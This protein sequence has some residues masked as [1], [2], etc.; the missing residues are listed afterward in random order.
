MAYEFFFSYT[1]ANNDPYLKLFFD[2]VSEVIRER[3]GLPANVPV[4]FF[5]QRELEL[6]E[7]WDQA[8]VD[9]LQTSRVF[10]AVWSPGYFKSEYCGKEWALVVSPFIPERQTGHGRSLAAPLARPRN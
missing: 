10:L 3:R 9:A 4:G 2:A 1:R 5:D 6:G 8:I 7:D